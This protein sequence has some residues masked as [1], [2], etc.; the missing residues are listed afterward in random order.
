MKNTILALFNPENEFFV[1]TKDAKR[2]THISLSSFILPVIFLALAGVLTQFLFAPLFFGDPTQAST[3]ARQAFG[4]YV[5]FG[6]VIGAIFLWVRFYE[7]RPFNTI[8]LTKEGAL[9]KYMFGFATGI[10]MNTLVVG[11]MAIF[12]SIE[13]TSENAPLTDIN[14]IGVVTIFL[15]GFVI[16]GASEELLTRGWM[17]QVI[18]ARYKPWLGVLITSI[19]FAAVHLGNSGINPFAVINLFLFALLMTLFVMRDGSIWAACGWHSAW[20]WTLGNVYGL[21]VSGR[22]DVISIFDLNT[23]GNE[24]LSGGGFGPEGSV[25]TTLVLFVAIIWTGITIKNNRSN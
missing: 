7:G 18:G 4:L 19:F 9:K 21:S 17:F 20:N 23:T 16:Q 10:L 5:M 2:I 1:L 25:I 22:G 12:G 8:G 3:I 11:I 14:A 13:L 15:F 24:I 6:T